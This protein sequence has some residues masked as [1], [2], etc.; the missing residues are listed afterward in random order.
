MLRSKEQV[1]AILTFAYSGVHWRHRHIGCKSKIKGSESIRALVLSK[2]KE[3]LMK[4]YVKEAVFNAI[5]SS[6]SHPC[7]YLKLKSLYGI[8]MSVLRP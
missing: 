7:K 4:G 3:A 6:Y 1:H 5:N 8:G 2:E